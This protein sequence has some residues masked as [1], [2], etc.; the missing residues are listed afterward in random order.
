MI[1]GIIDM[2]IINKMEEVAYNGKKWRKFCFQQSFA[3]KITIITF[4][5]GESESVVGLGFE[6]PSSVPVCDI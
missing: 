5:F 1:F 6:L 2:Y 3:L 4:T